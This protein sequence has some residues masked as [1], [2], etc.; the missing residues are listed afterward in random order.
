ML[1]EKSNYTVTAEKVD[2]RTLGVLYEQA[3]RKL[4]IC[5]DESPKSEWV[6]IGNSYYWHP[7]ETVTELEQRKI[8]YD[9][10]NWG[11]ARGW[12]FCGNGKDLRIED[13][14][15]EHR[16]FFRKCQEAERGWEEQRKKFY[17]SVIRSAKPWWRFW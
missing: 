2:F 12:R 1:A 10:N 11:Q 3:G 15:P 4:T 6:A 8:L 9:L 13:V 5:F 14:A 7:G 16:E 17:D